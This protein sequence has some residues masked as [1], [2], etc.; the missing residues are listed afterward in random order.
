M[1][2]HKLMSTTVDIYKGRI[3][4]NGFAEGMKQ[5]DMK[6]YERKMLKG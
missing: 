6:Q 3:T 5:Y 2:G 1:A 4:A